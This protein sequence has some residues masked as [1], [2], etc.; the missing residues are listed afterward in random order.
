MGSLDCHDD[1]RLYYHDD[2]LFTGVA[3]T[4]NKDGTLKCEVTYQNGLPWG[5]T[6]EW[7]PSG[8]PLVDSTLVMGA[9]HGRAREWHA[10]GQIA[11]DG[12]YEYG[13]TLWEKNWDEN[14]QIVHDYQMKETDPDYQTLQRYRARYAGKSAG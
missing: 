3:F 11:E 2:K 5:P 10:N 1:D 12:E 6:K 13:L 8:Q 4:Q 7:Y 9:L 14:G